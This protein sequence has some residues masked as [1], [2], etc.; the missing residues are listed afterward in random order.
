[1]KN[2]L[3]LTQKVDRND[4]IL[5]FF[6][7]WIEEFAHRFQKVTVICLYK[8][9]YH[10]PPNVKVLSLGKDEG[11]GRLTY[12]TRLYSYIW[13]E[14]NNY[15]SVY[16]HMNPIYIVL[17]G[18]V[19]RLMHKKIVL[20]YI[21]RN[22]D[23]KLRIAEKFAHKIFSS[24]K[25]AFRVKSTKVTFFGHGIDTERFAYKHKNEHDPITI[26]HVGRITKIKNC[27]TLIEA[28]AILKKELQKNFEIHFVGAPLTTEDEFYKADLINRIE[29]HDLS[30]IVKFVG[31]VANKNM[32][33]VYDAADLSVNLTPT[34][35]MDKVVLES[36]STG[37][38]ALTANEA[39]VD[40]L[41]RY[42]AQ[43]LYKYR[44]A[45]DLA[46]RLSLS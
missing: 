11:K 7:R 17:C 45:Q 31:S 41:D 22:V 4:D 6:H 27:D 9:T 8:G 42:K 46:Q 1:M 43:L 35:G 2:I 36:F 20:S 25:E 23:L 33:A 37:T 19:W 24:T 21:H 38:L 34:G 39:F 12:L 26:I 5:G 14:R 15:D 44:D 10:L 3:I 28:A 40:F 32:A 16:V 29:K 30:R 18:I 13:H